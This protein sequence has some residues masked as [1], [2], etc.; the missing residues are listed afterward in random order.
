[1][2]HFNFACGKSRGSGLF[3]HPRSRLLF[4]CLLPSSDRSFSW[5]VHSG[6]PLDDWSSVPSGA[7]SQWSDRLSS[8]FRNPSPP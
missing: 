8:L 6:S 2:H 5:A 7:A 1:M 4:R 3:R